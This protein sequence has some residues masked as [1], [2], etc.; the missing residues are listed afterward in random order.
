MRVF[1]RH[2]QAL[3]RRSETRLAEALKN[4]TCC[5]PITEDMGKPVAIKVAGAQPR[6]PYGDL[7]FPVLSDDQ[8][9]VEAK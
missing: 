1:I 8:E 6:K 7:L 3:A 5:F 4:I 9:K 2:H